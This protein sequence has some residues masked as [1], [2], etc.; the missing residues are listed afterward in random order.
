[1]D[2]LPVSYIKPHMGAAPSAVG[3]VT[4]NIAGLDF[5]VVDASSCRRKLSGRGSAD[6]IA[7]ICI[8]KTGKA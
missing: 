1:M 6:R 4:D 5:A 8:N 2:N 3:G 7:K